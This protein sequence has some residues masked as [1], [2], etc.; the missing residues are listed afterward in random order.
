MLQLFVGVLLGI[1]LDQTFTLPSV[2][3]Y[4]ESI[5]NKVNNKDAEQ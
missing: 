1:W 4:I 5:T 3:E 2:Q